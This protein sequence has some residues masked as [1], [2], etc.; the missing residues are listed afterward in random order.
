V[1]P[2]P[3]TAPG[4]AMWRVIAF[5]YTSHDAAAKKAKRVNEKWPDLRASVFIPK[6]RRGYYLVA[7]GGRMT[8]EDAVRLQRKARGSGLPRD[9]YVQNYSE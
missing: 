4:R 7:L 1:Q 5:T 2:R 6:E 3:V 9:T 8:R